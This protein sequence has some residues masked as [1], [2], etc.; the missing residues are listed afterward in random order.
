MVLARNKI[1]Y[2]FLDIKQVKLFALASTKVRGH[3]AKE[4]RHIIRS[5][6]AA[7]KAAYPGRRVWLE[8][9]LAFRVCE[10]KYIG[11]KGFQGMVDGLIDLKQG[12]ITPASSEDNG[13][14]TEG[15]SHASDEQ[16]KDAECD[17]VWS[18]YLTG[19]ATQE[20]VST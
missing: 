17:I 4:W 8:K 1:D 5:I 3:L 12:D 11:G 18:G 2:N 6:Y 9:R 19:E 7:A 20:F 14:S 13:Q 16:R 15:E 10:A